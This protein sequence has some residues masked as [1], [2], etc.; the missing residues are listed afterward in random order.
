MK[1][2]TQRELIRT[3]A[4]NWRRAYG[5]DFS[6]L[7]FSR[8][9]DKSR[10]PLTKKQI[11]ER[12]D[13]LDGETATAEEVNAIIGNKLWTRL[14]C[15]ECGRED[16]DAVLVVGEEPDYDSC[17]ASL[18]RSCVQQAALAFQTPP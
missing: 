8:H 18:C 6:D 11:M 2:T 5:P 13:A 15:D 14:V 9:V 10:H 16:A 1:L 17:T 3:V 12:L 7:H 4:A